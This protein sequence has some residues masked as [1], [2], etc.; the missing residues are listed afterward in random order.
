[1]NGI[2]SITEGSMIAGPA[3]TVAFKP[4]SEVAIDITEEERR[5]SALFQ[6]CDATKPGDVIVLGALGD[7]SGIVG[8]CIALGFKTKG[9]DGIV[10]DG[11]VRDTHVIKH[12]YKY[13]VFAKN[14]TPLAGQVFSMDYNVPVSCGG[15]VVRPGDII[16]GDDDGVV[17]VPAHLLEEVVEYA[18]KEVRLEDSVRESIREEL[19]RGASLGELYPPRTR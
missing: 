2:R 12:V 19:P 18:E 6:A 8:D 4:M 11:G 14:V 3:V 5:K 7:A 1:M 17:V 10:I 9:A 13:P 15:V 16:V